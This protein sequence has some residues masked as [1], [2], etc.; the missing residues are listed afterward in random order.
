MK[1]RNL[2]V[3]VIEAASAAALQTAIETFL[4]DGDERDLVE[5]EFRFDGD[6]YVVLILYTE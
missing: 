5:L 2:R 1:L 6:D 4:A 3:E